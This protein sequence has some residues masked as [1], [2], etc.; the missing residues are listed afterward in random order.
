MAETVNPPLENEMCKL[1]EDIKKLVN[2]KY[3]F[4]TKN[5][6]DCSINQSLSFSNLRIEFKVTSKKIV[7]KKS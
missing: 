7:R 5:D 3:A 1:M 2:E 6:T 4:I